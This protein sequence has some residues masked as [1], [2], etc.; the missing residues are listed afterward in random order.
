MRYLNIPYESDYYQGSIDYVRN[1]T[2]TYDVVQSGDVTVSTNA[3]GS[4][5]L[6]SLSYPLGINNENHKT[7]VGLLLEGAYYQI[8]FSFL[9]L[10]LESYTYQCLRN[11]LFE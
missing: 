6:Y 5:L 4:Q 11:D 2:R 9:K 7:G 10:K 8:H 1:V 3:E